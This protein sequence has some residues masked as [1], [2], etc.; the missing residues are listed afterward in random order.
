MIQISSGATYNHF[1]LLVLIADSNDRIPELAPDFRGIALVHGTSG[2][3]LE[4]PKPY[5]PDDLTTNLLLAWSFWSLSSIEI[6][7]LQN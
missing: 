3:I 2:T 1:D 7:A 6:L 5:T 4:Y